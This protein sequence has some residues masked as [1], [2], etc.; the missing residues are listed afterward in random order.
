MND[1]HIESM[2][3][4]HAWPDMPEGARRRLD[5]SLRTHA[6][7]RRSRSVPI[8]AGIG[9]AL[10]LGG[11]VGYQLAPRTVV[12]DAAPIADRA[13]HTPPLINPGHDLRTAAA[14]P[15]RVVI[16][17]SVFAVDRPSIVRASDP[18]AWG[19]LSTN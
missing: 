17:A 12:Q 1:K 13:G 11:V 8:A 10:I 14:T 16:N 7:Q 18:A 4:D 19:S 5:G 2:L 6:T 15:N 9:T 3:D